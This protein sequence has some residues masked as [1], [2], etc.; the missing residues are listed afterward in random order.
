MELLVGRMFVRNVP[1]ATDEV[2]F[3]SHVVRL[4]I[5]LCSMLSEVFVRESS[6]QGICVTISGNDNLPK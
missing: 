4:V 3:K 1:T 2:G 6:V 5:L